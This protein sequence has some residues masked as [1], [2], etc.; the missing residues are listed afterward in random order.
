M[1]KMM[2]EDDGTLG[3]GF[4]RHLDC[5]VLRTPRPYYPVVFTDYHSI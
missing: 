1:E 5:V 2:V 3:L 4:T